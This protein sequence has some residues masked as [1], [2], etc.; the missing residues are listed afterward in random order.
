MIIVMLGAPGSG[1]GTVGSLL[2]E[3]FRIPHISSGEIFRSYIKKH[4]DLGKELEQYVVSGNLVPD[5]L[6]IRIVEKRLSEEDVVNGFILD[7]Y[8]R[9][10]NQA[11]ELDE[12]LKNNN[13]KI[14]VAANLSLPDEEIIERIINR[15][16]CTNVSCRQIYN[17]QYKP[18]RE[19]G[20]CDN[21]GSKLILRKDDN[22]ETIR[23]RLKVYH[24][25]SKD[26]IH[27]YK[28]KDILYTLKVNQESKKTTEDIA[29]EINKH[30]RR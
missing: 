3:N 23:Q 27:Y 13:K 20:V 28:E 22:E 15:R 6:A 14:K 2:S 7:G 19:E 5:E 25:A 10:K 29:E 16:T 9:T 24:E 30:V 1:K 21:C 8:P 12:L 18:P 26:L 11:I 4:N 17:L